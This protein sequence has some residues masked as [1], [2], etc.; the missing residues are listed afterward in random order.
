MSSLLKTFKDPANQLTGYDT[1][2]YKNE[3]VLTKTHIFPLTITK[4]DFQLVEEV[5]YTLICFFIS[6]NDKRS[7]K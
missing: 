4:A 2:F 6:N 5:I 3:N 1:Y 7:N